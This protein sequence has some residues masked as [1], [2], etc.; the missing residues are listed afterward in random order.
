MNFRSCFFRLKKVIK[1]AFKTRKEKIAF[2][3]GFS[4][5]KKEIK[6]A[7]KASKKQKGDLVSVSER[8]NVRVNK[9]W[10]KSFKKEYPYADK[11][12]ERLSEYKD[13]KDIY[14]SVNDQK[15]LEDWAKADKERYEA[16]NHRGSFDTRDFFEAALR[17]SY[18]EK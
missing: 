5:G 16:E 1:I 9:A 11:V 7:E 13:S 6:K 3:I 17:K 18:S 15:F 8:K 10:L 4:R 2:K 14:A 12:I